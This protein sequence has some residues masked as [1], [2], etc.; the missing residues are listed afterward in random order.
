MMTERFTF[1]E[2][3][4]K[5]VSFD[6]LTETLHERAYTGVSVAG[7]SGNTEIDVTVAEKVNRATL[8]LAVR[9]FTAGARV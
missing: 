7:V 6:K 4:V 3:G 2:L 9:Q 5:F 1:T 8:L